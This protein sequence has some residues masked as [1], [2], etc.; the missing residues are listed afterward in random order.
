MHLK[1]GKDQGERVRS[2]VLAL[3]VLDY[4]RK[5]ISDEGFLFI[6][7]TEEV[8]I[9]GTEIVYIGGDKIKPAVKSLREA[10]ENRLSLGELDLLPRSFD[11]IGDIAILNMP[12]ALENQKKVVGRALLETFKHIRVVAR[13]KTSVETEF[14]TRQLE[15][16]AGENRL[17]TVHKEFG[18]RYKLNVESA[19]FSPRLGTERM[20]IASQ[21]KA[22]ERIL[23]LFAGIGPYPILIAKKATPSE[24]YGVELNPDA[25]SYMVENIRL[26]KVDVKPVLGDAG[27][28]AKR[29]GKFDRI[30]MPLPKDAGSFLDSVLPSLEKDG[31]INFYDFSSGT[32]ESVSRVET[33]CNRLG[34][35]IKVLD[36]VKCG[37][38]S[39]G[40]FRVCV[41]F[42]VV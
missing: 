34:Y 39:P 27:K 17:E 22:G 23:V 40:V 2:R 8:N 35:S 19:Y 15:V 37:T 4:S 20:R 16:I 3:G 25:F 30:I 31:I 7:I 36:A 13:K 11:V 26:N 38:Y 21:V 24:I 5:I 1:A 32:K 41:D 29:L 9:S 10:L 28:E 6:P 42:R 33:V 14:R 12:N 18:C